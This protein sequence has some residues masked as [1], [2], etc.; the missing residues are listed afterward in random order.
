MKSYL[1][2]GVAL[3]LASMTACQDANTPSTD[4]P[5]TETEAAT[6]DP[7]ATQAALVA[8]SVNHP[9]RPETATADDAARKPLEVLTFAGVKPGDTVMELEAG[10][11][12]YSE[13]MS[14]IVGP[15]GKIILQNPPAFDSFLGEEIFTALLGDDGSRL[16]NVVRSKT[17]FDALDADDNS[18]DVVTWV[19]GPH[20][21]WYKGQD[22]QT[23][24]GD[25]DKTYAEIA[26]ILKPGGVY[27]A[28]DHAAAPG[29]PETTGGTTHRID[30]AK[31]RERA[32][33]AGLVFVGESDALRNPDDNYEV[34]VFDPS[35][36]RKTDRFLH[37]YRK[38]D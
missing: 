13:L 27:I 31:V 19:L 21:L 18:V 12:Y 14:R 24:F 17:N 34:M 23:D 22:G 38:P 2:I 36:R 3:S 26:R 10:G 25:P 16:P 8:A 5:V 37:K 6:V 35:V 28:L 9:D 30:P 1:L 33:A 4:A 32:E 29:A 7:K 11:G 20:E 15:E